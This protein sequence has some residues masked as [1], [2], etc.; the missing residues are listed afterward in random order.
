MKMNNFKVT[1]LAIM[2]VLGATSIGL[3][4]CQ[5]DAQIV[6]MTSSGNVNGTMTPLTGEFQFNSVN[7]Q[8]NEGVLEF[9]TFADYENI[10]NSEEITTLTEFA[11]TCESSNLL[12]NYYSGV[13]DSTKEQYEFLG[14]LLNRD[15]IIKIDEFLIL[16]DFNSSVVYA[17]KHGEPI[18]L[19]NAKNGVDGNSVVSFA[20]EDDVIEELKIY[21]T[22]GLFCSAQ[23]QPS[24]EKFPSNGALSTNLTSTQP[25][26]GGTVTLPV[27]INTSVK[28]WPAGIYFELNS[29]VVVTPAGSVLAT[30]P[31][32]YT[33]TYS[34]T[35]RCGN[36]FNGTSTRSFNNASNDKNVMYWNVRALKKGSTSIKSTV[37]SS[38]SVPAGDTRVASY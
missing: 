37:T 22:R 12:A 21:K 18:E 4:S 9:A 1:A 10:T 3:V 15:G 6:D 32:S 27:M 28:Y 35:R 14:K 17:K 33:T 7:Y 23:Y 36:S 26:P 13:A 30:A 8:I 24:F 16:I 5:K 34:C 19:I 20:I 11:Q 25:T 31:F 29:R 2:M 38:A